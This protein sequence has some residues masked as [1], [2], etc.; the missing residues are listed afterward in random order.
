[1]VRGVPMSMNPAFAAQFSTNP[2]AIT[3]LLDDFGTLLDTEWKLLLTLGVVL[4]S[5]MYGIISAI[6]ICTSRSI[7]HWG[8]RLSLGL[9]LVSF[10]TARVDVH[11]LPGWAVPA[12]CVR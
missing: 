1:M 8:W 4:V 9:C 7:V 6:I 5:L 10:V 3:D 12:S 2:S 11:A